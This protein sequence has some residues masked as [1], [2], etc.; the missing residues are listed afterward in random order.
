MHLFLVRKQSE[1]RTTNMDPC[2]ALVNSRECARAMRI[3]LFSAVLTCSCAQNQD[4][5]PNPA[6]VV[7][8]R[9]TRFTVLSDAMVRMEH[10]GSKDNRT[11]N[12]LNDASPM[13]EDRPS[14]AFV[15]RKLPVPKFQ[16]SHPTPSS[17]VIETSALVLTYTPDAAP[18]P[19]PPV[20]SC[21]GATG[22]DADCGGR[23]CA[24]Y[25]SPSAPQGY[26]H[27]TIS[28]CCSRCQTSDDCGVW[29]HVDSDNNK[30]ATQCWL[31]TSAVRMRASADR[32]VGGN[33]T[34]EA[35]FT[36]ETLTVHV[37]RTSAVW[38]PGDIPTGN[39][40]GTQR[41]L[42]GTT[43]W[44]ELR[45]WMPGAVQ[46]PIN[47]C[48][49]APISR[50]GWA[51][52]EDA[53]NYMVDPAT[54]WISEENNGRSRDASD[55]YFFAHGLD[56]KGALYDYS[57]V[58]GSVPRIPRFLLGVWWSR[59]WPYTAEDLLEIADGYAAHTLPIDIL[60]SDMAWH[61]HNES[62]IDWGGYAWS[63]E[64]F[65]EHTQFQ[66]ELSDRGLNTVLNLHLDPV[67]HDVDPSYFAF[68]AKLGISNATL[69][70][71]GYPSIPGPKLPPPYDTP[72]NYDKSAV[73]P[74]LK[75]SQ[76]FGE[77]Y[78]DVLDDVG[79][80]WWWLD[81]EPV[82]TARILFERSQRQR[83]DGNG[84][85]FSRW[86]GLGSHRYPIGFSGDTYMEWVT[87]QFQTSFTVAAANVLFWWSH[88]I[89][90]HR[91]NRDFA[92]YDPE[93][94]LRWLQWGTHAPILRTHPQPDP[95]VERRPYGYGLPIASYMSD[96]M[97]RRGRLVPFLASALRT[98]E[99]TA[100][101]PIRG[102]YIDHPTEA[103]AYLYNDTFTYCDHMVVAP[104]T[105]NVSNVTLMAPRS[106]WL[107]AGE[108]VDMV[109]L[110]T[111]VSPAHG[112]VLH[113]NYTL[114]ESPSWVRAGTMI[115]LAPQPT[116]TNALG[117]A[118][119]PAVQ[120]KAGWEVW[121]GGAKMGG[122]NVTTDDGETLESTY[123]IST[124]GRSIRLTTAVSADATETFFEIKGVLRAAAVT[125]CTSAASGTRGITGMALSYAATTLTQTLKVTLKPS[126][127]GTGPSTVCMDV[128]APFPLV[129]SAQPAGRGGYVGRRMRAHRLKA[130]VDDAL[131][132]PQQ[133]AMPLVLA[134]NSAT[135]IVADCKRNDGAAAQAELQAFDASLQHAMKG[136]MSSSLAGQSLLNTSLLVVAQHWLA[137]YV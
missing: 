122:G 19:P 12:N 107:P 41:S 48:N 135:R 38:H 86:G 69:A 101:S 23:E 66:S 36:N 99:T 119:D 57:L 39:M 70:Q 80:N 125:P 85:A 53:G 129:A 114:W 15:N 59:Y 31:L 24:E 18:P 92:A 68:A 26:P 11:S 137:P 91:S 98:F 104:V 28:E 121:I 123:A 6:A 10:S 72:N 2:R 109:D 132:N 97:R 81:D 8:F 44:Q 133:V 37:K 1:Q 79:T 42:D 45:C 54:Q 113:R 82:W 106:V 43:G 62:H 14:L 9:N 3:L 30:S 136:L 13:F 29:I 131:H 115:P 73:A 87:L 78:L 76:R 83:E 58:A 117:F 84:I 46:D 89:G 95:L 17:I 56:F 103:Q 35:S 33:F 74:L 27:L 65:P 64:L 110:A 75:S 120:G 25:R 77:A 63:P 134:V 124:D 60:V 111:I 105:S 55:L 93:L 118:S 20:S 102:L 47:G 5:L 108:W 71:L 32:T 130:M 90:G 49:L 100:V 52:Y 88:D 40:L 21:N 96:A 128:T 50:D 67:Q 34:A 16:V 7:A 116:S 112:L 94:Y 22:Y 127:R 126:V 51:V 61:F 4:P